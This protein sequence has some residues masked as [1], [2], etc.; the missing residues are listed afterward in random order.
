MTQLGQ[1]GLAGLVLDGERTSG[2]DIRSQNVTAAMAIA[3]IVKTSLG[4]VGLDKM[5]VD[6]VGDVTITNDGATIL[7]QLD[8]QH[9]AAKVLCQLADLQDQEVGDG[10]TSVVIVAAELLSR[11][12][13]LVKSKVHPTTIISGYRLAMKEAVRYIREQLLV[14]IDT[15]GPGS[16]FALYH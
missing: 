15:L 12:N 2:Q 8:V 1:R 13:E 11:A 6:E 16:I 7:K 5:L 3:N 10:T 9:P 4:P 14:Q